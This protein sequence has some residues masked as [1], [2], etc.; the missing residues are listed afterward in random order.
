MS[1]IEVEAKLILTVPEPTEN[2]EAADIVLAV[3]QHLN[4]A[5]GV[6]I[7][8]ETSTQVGFRIHVG[9]FNVLQ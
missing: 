5:E 9:D 3:E 7:M 6:I 2:E 4:Y 1:R 8:P